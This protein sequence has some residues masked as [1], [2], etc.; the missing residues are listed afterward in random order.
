MDSEDQAHWVSDENMDSIGN[1][2][3]RHLCS[4]LAKKLS[5]VCHVLSLCEAE[6]KSNALVQMV[7]EISRQSSIQ[8]KA[9]I[10]LTAFSQIYNEN[11]EQ[12]QSRKTWKT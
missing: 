4:I 9:W 7:E 1:W 3:R 11:W 8:S 6:F 2:T 10:L 5:I 12:K